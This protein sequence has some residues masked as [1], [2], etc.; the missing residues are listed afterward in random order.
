[1][2]M[3]TRILEAAGEA[4]EREGL[5]GLS[6]RKVAAKVGLTPMALYRHYADKQ[7]LV[8]AITLE[9][10]EAWRA[11][12][13]RVRG[14][15]PLQWLEK[16]GDAFLDF[17]LQEPR[18]FEAAFLLRANSARQFPDDFIAGRSPP[19]A[20]VSDQIE[21]A[22]SEGLL[23]DAP[24]PEIVLSIWAMAQGLVGLYRAGRFAGDE[25]DFRGL[26]RS[27]LRR[28]ISAFRPGAPS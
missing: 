23:G 25:Q 20:M 18:R 6:M 21:R 24:T 22:K 19:V 11:R 3:K 17:A 28:C 14:D 9:G 1:M 10:L 12:V 7:A 5:D 27:A 26:F 8:D 16:M 13:S 15:D 2:D 4:F